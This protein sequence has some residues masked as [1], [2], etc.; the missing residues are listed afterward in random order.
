M[1]GCCYTPT[2]KDFLWWYWLLLASIVGIPML[3][4]V[5]YVGRYPKADEEEKKRR[6]KRAAW[7]SG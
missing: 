1:G 3:L 2:K 5:L 6:G 7:I 4:A